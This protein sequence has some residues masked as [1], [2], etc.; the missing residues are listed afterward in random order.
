M[1]LEQEG[2]KV[3]GLSADEQPQLRRGV[4]RDGRER[5]G[6]AGE[7]ARVVGDEAQLVRRRAAAPVRQVR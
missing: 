4:Q 3:D 6:A 1:H 5:E 2:P 7:D